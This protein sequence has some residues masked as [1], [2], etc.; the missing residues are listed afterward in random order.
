[1]R[2]SVSLGKITSVKFGLCGHNED[3][4]GL[5][6]SFSSAGKVVSFNKSYYDT[7]QVEHTSR[8]EWSPEDRVNAHNATIE[9]VSKLLNDAGVDDINKLVNKPVELTFDANDLQ[10]W[11]ILT[12]V[13]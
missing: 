8:C 12:E 3:E 11:R 5:K 13:L 4:I 10:E 1:M 2:K 7:H 9:Y 6:L